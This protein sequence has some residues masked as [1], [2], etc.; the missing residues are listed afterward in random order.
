[1]ASKQ[2]TLQL[3]TAAYK[4]TV[5]VNTGLFI[6]GKWVDPAD[7]GTIDVINPATGKLITTVSAGT[8]KDVDVAVD[9]AKKAFKDS[10]GLKVPG[11][12]RAKLLNKLADLVEAN[13]EE[14]AALES[15]DTGELSRV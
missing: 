12:E 14:L 11:T 3:D 6:G 1:M 8:D 4:G 7:G 9:I 10:W 13:L 15:L 2:F 5:S